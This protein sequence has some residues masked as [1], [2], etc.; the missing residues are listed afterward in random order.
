MAGSLPSYY[1]RF[2]PT[3]NYTRH[4]FRAGMVLQSAELNEIQ[5]AAAHQTRSIGDALFKDGD[6]VRDARIIVD[7]V[8]GKTICESGAIYLAGM[9]RGVPPGEITIPV[10][11]TI[12]VG[13]YLQESVVTEQQD[14]SLL[15]PASETRNYNE[16][17]AG[18]LKVDP[19]WGYQG[20]GQAGD[21]FPIYY[22][23][24]GV[25]RGKDAPPV[26]DSVS[27]A[28]ARYD[29][30]STTSNYVVSGLAVSMMADA[31]NSQQYNVK[32][33]RARVNGQA[34]DLATSVRVVYPAQPVIRFIDSEPKTSD[35][36]SLQRVNVDRPPLKNITQVRITREKS[37]NVS[38][39]P[40]AGT[41]DSL[42]DTAVVEIVSITQGGVTYVRGT[43]YKLTGGQVDWSLA[44]A[45]PLTGSTYTCVYR[46]IATVVPQ[47][48]DDKGFSVLG[49]VPGT[50]IMTNY[51]TMLPRIDRLCLTDEGRLVWIEG[52]STDY[53][54]VRPP[55]PSTMLALAQVYQYWDDRR[56]IV[57]DG[58][59][60]V[61]M[62]TLEAYGARLDLLTDLIAQH[63]LIADVNT[64][65]AVAK[66]GLFVDPFLD[67][68]HRDQGLPQTAASFDNFLMLPVAA[69]PLRPSADVKDITMCEYVLEPILEQPARTGSMQVNPYM[70][71]G[72]EPGRVTLDPAIDRWT[73][74]QTSW[75]SPVTR[76]FFINQEIGNRRRRGQVEVSNVVNTS[77]QLLSTSESTLEFLRQ[78]DVQFRLEGFGSGELITAVTFDGLPVTAV[79]V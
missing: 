69:T 11:G 36:L 19:K 68:T 74:K 60:V 55:V 40:A 44:G 49:A 57:N 15:D 50:L 34:I 64:R 77:T 27:Q 33:G 61:P 42:P 7:A 30:D 31:G 53:N 51:N 46:Y 71:F 12:M 63:G 1:N 78:I 75:A 41:R 52:V 16:P 73:E 76:Q 8:N 32:E 62:A 2:D 28:I 13:I 79:P 70:A 66:K 39:G 56:Y 45:E 38:R 24:E 23:D 26:L 35:T 18:R 47:D 65:E 14:P 17:G 72:I 6:V 20:D 3:K 29:R 54:P 5:D 59:R 67:D 9:V 4:M 25:L 37:A 58:V 21:F 48:V 43:D 10:A 22:V